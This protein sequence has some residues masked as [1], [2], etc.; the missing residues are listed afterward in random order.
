[1]KTLDRYGI[2]PLMCLFTVFLFARRI[3]V[4]ALSG[5]NLQQETGRNFDI[6]FF[7]A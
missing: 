4:P 2:L 5:R 1:M 6:A 7:L 3:S